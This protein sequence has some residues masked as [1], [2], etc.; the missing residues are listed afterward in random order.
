M[1]VYTIARCCNAGGSPA[2]QPTIDPYGPPY[3]QAPVYTPPVYQPPAAGTAECAKDTSCF[4]TNYECTGCC[5]TG[6]AK[7]GVGCWDLVYT[8]ARCCNAGGSVPALLQ[9]IPYQPTVSTQ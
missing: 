8:I 5:S 7:N 1:G 6:I 2:F 9:A 3:T 4:D